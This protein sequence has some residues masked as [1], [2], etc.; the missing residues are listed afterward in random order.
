MHETHSCLNGVCAMSSG[1]VE[2]RDLPV[3][4]AIARE[5]TLGAAARRLGQSQP[6]MGRRLRALEQATG[7]ALF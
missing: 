2:W 4:L 1:A 3:F 6:T 7:A 5:G